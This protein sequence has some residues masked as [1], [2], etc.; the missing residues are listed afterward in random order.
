METAERT[1][2]VQLFLLICVF[3]VLLG[4]AASAGEPIDI[5]SR[6]ELFVDDHLID[7]MD[8]VRLLLNRPQPAGKVLAFDKPWE[9]NTSLCDGF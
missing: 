8:G 3:A 5:G 4:P 6:R 7:S 2:S 1:G 9:G